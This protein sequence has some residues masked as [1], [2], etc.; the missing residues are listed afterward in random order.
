MA[1]TKVSGIIANALEDIRTVVDANT[2][3]GTPIETNSGTTIIPVSKVSM[4]FAT[5]GLD[6]NGNQEMNKAQ[7]FGAGGGTGL[8]IQPIGFLVVDP[9]GDVDMINVG[10]KNP[11]DP[12]EQLS[13]LIERSPEIIS[14]IK[15]IFA[16]D[17]SEN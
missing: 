11:S 9:D 7:N 6:Y 1:E 8:S 17:K 3:I 10:V 5:G 4:G 16:K 2:I 15:A 12:I 14:K 13:D